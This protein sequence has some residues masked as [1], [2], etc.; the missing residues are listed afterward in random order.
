M[1][2]IYGAKEDLEQIEAHAKSIHLST[3]AFVRKTVM[4]EISRHPTKET[5]EEQVAR[6]VK[7]IL[8][9]DGIINN[10]ESNT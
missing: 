8:S 5:L 7:K 10:Q 6:I 3:S 2:R 1:L 9:E 4:A